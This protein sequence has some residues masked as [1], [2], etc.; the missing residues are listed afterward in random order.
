MIYIRAKTYIR[1]FRVFFY[2]YIYVC[3]YIGACLQGKLARFTGLVNT[4]FVVKRKVNILE[5][6]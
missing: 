2:E 3:M 4:R 6:K 5:N 1:S